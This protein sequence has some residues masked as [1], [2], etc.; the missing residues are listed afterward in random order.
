MTSTFVR[1]HGIWN[2]A[3]NRWVQPRANMA[4]RSYGLETEFGYVQTVTLILD[5]WPWVKVKTHPGIMK[6]TVIERIIILIQHGR[7][8]LWLRH[9]FWVYVHCDLHFGDLTWGPGYD[10]TLDYRE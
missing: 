9:G 10:K 4:V 2:I 8:E 1:W 5:I 6:N 7:E 3:W